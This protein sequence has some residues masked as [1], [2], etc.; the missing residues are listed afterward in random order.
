MDF[1]VYTRIQLKFR[2]SWKFATPVELFTKRKIYRFL[3]LLEPIQTLVKG[4]Q[5]L[6][7]LFKS[8]E[9]KWNKK[10]KP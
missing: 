1:I 3:L 7:S 6:K 10:P 2:R 5:D 8:Q 9:L 4:S